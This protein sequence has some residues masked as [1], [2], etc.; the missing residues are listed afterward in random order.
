MKELIFSDVGCL[1]ISSDMREKTYIEAVQ[2]C[3]YFSEVPLRLSLFISR[4]TLV[5]YFF[6]GFP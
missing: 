6:Q 1:A 3:N 4:V 2:N 5:D